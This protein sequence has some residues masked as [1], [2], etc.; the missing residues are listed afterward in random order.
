MVANKVDNKVGGEYSG[1]GS[2]GLIDKLVRCRKLQKS[3][4]Q[5]PLNAQ[6]NLAS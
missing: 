4:G 5:K 3:E 2:S 6:E 1:N